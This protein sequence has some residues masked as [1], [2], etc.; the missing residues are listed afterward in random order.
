MSAAAV[1]A[2]VVTGVL[3]AALAFYLIWVVLILRRLTDTLGKVVFGVASIA[4]R[5]QPIG[6]IVGELNGDLGAVADALEEL[7]R[8]VDKAP[9]SRAS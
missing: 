3:V 9:Q 7:A 8:D 5:V 1:A 6:P 4:H 2:I